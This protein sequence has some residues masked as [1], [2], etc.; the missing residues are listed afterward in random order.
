MEGCLN[1]RGAKGI[2][3]MEGRDVKQPALM[4]DLATARISVGQVSQRIIHSA[5]G[6]DTEQTHTLD[7]VRRVIDSET[8][9]ILNIRATQFSGKE[10]SEA[11][12]RYKAARK[13]TLRW[14]KNYTEMDFRSL[15]SYT[16]KDLANIA[17]EPEA[18]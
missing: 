3:S 7:S 6:Q 1:G 11:E 12:S 18:F 13:I 8:A 16:R 15:G 2:N 5:V 9:D 10:L 17:L 4:E 14:I